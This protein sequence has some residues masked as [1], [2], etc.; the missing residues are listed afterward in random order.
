MVRTQS[1]RFALVVVVLAFAVGGI[2]RLKAAAPAPRRSP[3]VP[4]WPFDQNHDQGRLLESIE[5]HN[6]IVTQQVETETDLALRH[7]RQQMSTDPAAVEDELKLLLGRV[8]RT[9]ELRAEVRATLRAKLEAALRES[10]R[11]AATKDL[12]DQQR[13]EADGAAMDRQRISQALERKQ[14]KLK[15]LMDRFDSLMDEGRYLA[16]DEIGELEVAKIAP[17]LPI[18]QSASLVAHMTGAREADLALRLARQKAVIDTLGTVEVSMMPMPDDQPIVYPP[19][20]EFQELSTR[21]KRYASTDLKKLTPA[22]KKIREALEAPTQMEFTETPLQDAVGYLKD[23]HSIEIQLDT[24]AM[25]DAGVGSDTPVSRVLN[26]VSLKS[27]LRLLLG[28]YDLTF[29]VKDEV[30]LITTQDKAESELVTKAYPVA[31]LVIPV[32][33]GRGMGGGMMG[34][35]GGGMMG[36]MGGGMGGGMMG[37]M[38]GGMGGMGGGMGGGMF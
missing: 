19:A 24:R 4:D 7:A 29:I 35:M 5:Q 10:S 2:V 30:L 21:R 8:V 33:S 28:E 17:E 38:G 34:G 9:P 18:A 6:R 1:F 22:E 23:L 27:A 20:D 26:G 32:R 37:G 15:Q 11:V 25:E 36:G 12:L 13:Q 3:T 31:D 16:A 14:E